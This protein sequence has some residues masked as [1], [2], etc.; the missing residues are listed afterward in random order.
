MLGGTTQKENGYRVPVGEMG[1]LLPT[2]Q[3]RGGFSGLSESQATPQGPALAA[4]HGR[5]D[6]CLPFPPTH[7]TWLPFGSTAA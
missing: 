6:P 3:R 1:P 7:L 4:L 5:R 2:I